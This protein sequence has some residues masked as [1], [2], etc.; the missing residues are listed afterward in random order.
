[1]N[2]MLFNIKSA[3]VFHHVKYN[4]TGTTIK[5][6]K[7]GMQCC[8]VDHQKKKPRDCHI[9]AGIIPS[10]LDMEKNDMAHT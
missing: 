3:L 2:M 5:Y 8:Y 1:M 7:W 6:Y 10:T 9:L 4:G